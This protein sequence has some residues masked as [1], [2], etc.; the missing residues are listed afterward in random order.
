MVGVSSFSYFLGVV[1][2]DG[3]WIGLEKLT[4]R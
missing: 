1:V 2:I 3:D 4:D